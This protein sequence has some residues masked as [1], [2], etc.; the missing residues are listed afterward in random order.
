MEVLINAIPYLFIAV[1]IVILIINNLLP[2]SVTDKYGVRGGMI[3][4][5]TNFAAAA[6]EF[7]LL[8]ASGKNEVRFSIFWDY[9]EK[10]SSNNGA[11]INAAYFR[12]NLITLFL[13][14]CIGIVMFASNLVAEETVTKKR[15]SYLNAII[16][17]T[18][19]MNGML[20]VTDLFSLY[21]FLEIVG[22]SSFVLI[23][24]FK[25]QKGLE[26]A[27][28]YLAMSSFATI[29][30]LFGLSFLFM[31]NGSLTY[32]SLKSLTIKPNGNGGAF[33]SYIALAALTAGFAI[34]AGA[35]PFHSWLPDAHQSADTS[36]SILLSGIVIKIA[37]IYGLIVLTD[38]FSEV[39]AIRLSLAVIG[40][41]TIMFG[42][43]LAMRQKHFKRICAYSSVSQMGYILL[44]L[45][46]GSKL[47]LIGALYHIFSHAVFKSTLFTNAAA[48]HERLHTLEIDEMGGLGNVMPTTSFSSIVAFLSTAGIPPF[49]GFWS[50]LL[51][52]LALWGSGAKVLGGAALIISIF[53][54]AYFL[55][56]QKKVFF[57][58]TNEKWR[59]VREVG[60]SI[61]AGEIVLTA[62]TIIGGVAFPLVLLLL[63]GTGL[64]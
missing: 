39:Y 10:I 3:L 64:M 38:L 5:V 28:K 43:L 25:T 22:I 35:A 45:S 37:G 1:P 40:V 57:G 30:I 23:S 11:Y 19:G 47:G 61:L 2:A 24:I 36:I 63:S 8:A 44:G 4:A 6:V 34:K 29:L 56:L 62:F 15:G 41:F 53:T 13:M 31:T 42:A 16:T 55:R 12:V 9:T 51:I 17:L 46:A 59:T 32:E 27:F 33:L 18:L 48:L 26:G 7:I 20:I 52:V 54:A 58:V 50:K 21:V 49:S 14:A 60:G